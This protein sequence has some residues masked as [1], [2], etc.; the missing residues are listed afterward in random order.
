MR[1]S[2]N[3]PNEQQRRE[4]DPVNRLKEELPLCV[5]G[6]GLLEFVDSCKA[7]N[8]LLCKR[9]AWAPVLIPAPRST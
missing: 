8:R 1:E 3:N 4:N 5:C 9:G 2:E 7:E 6:C